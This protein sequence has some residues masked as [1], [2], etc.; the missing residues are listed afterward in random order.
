MSDDENNMSTNVV[1]VDDD[2]IAVRVTPVPGQP[3]IVTLPP[4]STVR[5]VCEVAA[6]T[7]SSDLTY[8][9]NAVP[10]T[11]DSTVKD[12]DRVTIAMGAKGNN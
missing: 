11:L 9:V 7:P 8:Q 3:M 2:T 10:A 12:G 6:I 4:G 1:N 5:K